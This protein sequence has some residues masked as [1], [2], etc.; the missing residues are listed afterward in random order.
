[1]HVSTVRDH[2]HRGGP[3]YD[4]ETLCNPFSTQLV[5]NSALAAD[6]C[7]IGHLTMPDS[8]TSR[9]YFG[10]SPM[11]ML[12]LALERLLCVTSHGI[13]EAKFSV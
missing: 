3:F 9:V 2:L 10:S 5:L 7:Q 11:L 4:P 8:A 1:V 12:N 13:L 6:F